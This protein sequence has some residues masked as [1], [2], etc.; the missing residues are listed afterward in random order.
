MIWFK[1]E[2]KWKVTIRQKENEAEIEFVLVRKDNQGLV[3]NM[4]AIS[5]EC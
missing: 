1:R 4:K 3:R 5:G 2:G